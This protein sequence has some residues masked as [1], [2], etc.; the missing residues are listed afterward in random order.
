MDIDRTIVFAAD[1]LADA[2]SYGDALSQPTEVIITDTNRKRAR[3]W[4][5]IREVHG[6]TEQVGSEPLDYDPTD[7]RLPIFDDLPDTA[8]TIG[9]HRGPIS[10]QAS[11]YGNP[12][13]YTP[14]DRAVLAVDG[15]ISTAWTVAAFSEARGE[16]I[17]IDLGGERALTDMTLV[18][19]QTSP[20]ANRHITEIA[21]RVDGSLATIIGL[22]ERS[23][24]PAGQPVALGVTGSSIEIEITDTNMARRA[25]YPGVSPVG[26]AEI[27]L[28]LGV[29]QEVIR[30]PRALVDA[31]GSELDRHAL[32][33]VLTRQRSNPREPV[34]DDPEPAMTRAVPLPDNRTFVV[35]G[36]GRLSAR[37]DATLIDELVG[38]T[39]GLDGVGLAVRSSVRLPGDLPSRPSAALDG[40][41]AS[42]WTGDFGVQT[43]QWIEV[44]RDELI[45]ESTITIDVVVD[46]IHSVP[47]VVRLFIDGVD[48]GPFNT[49]LGLENRDPDTTRRIEIPLP[50]AGR[51]VRLMIEA[52]AE[53]TTLDWYSNEPTVMP[54]SIAE[55]GLGPG[56]RFGPLSPI[57][58]GCRDDL[59]SIDGSPARVAVSGAA[60]DAL[61]RRELQVTG[62]EPV[63]VIGGE[64][65]IVTSD[66]RSTGIDIDQL[67]LRSKRPVGRVAPARPVET[68]RHSDVRLTVD[69]PA[70]DH[71]RWLVLGQSDNAGWRATVDGR[72]LGDAIVVDGF[73][74]AWL[75][76][77]GEVWVVDLEWMPQRLV[78]KAVAISGLMLLVTLGLV[79]RGRRDDQ[80]LP[81][82]P[83]GEPDEPQLGHLPFFR[84]R[85]PLLSARVTALVGVLATAFVA[86]NLPQ[87]LLLAPLLGS[88]VA[89][90][91][92]HARLAGTLPLG[93]AFS[94]GMAA[95]YVMAEQIKLRHPSDFVWPQQF[96]EVHILGVIAILMLAGEYI[97]ITAR[98]GL[99]ER[100]PESSP[101]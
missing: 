35:S 90:A 63:D 6:Y 42:A 88:A 68:V 2:D 25:T 3:R 100:S 94:L 15:D 87:W 73:A 45:D 57:D 53:R 72:D 43:G 36:T 62:C 69:V 70:A 19:P 51:V 31:L 10:I 65:L 84:R 50:A 40:D 95:L 8:R 33:V 9:E 89:I 12:V 86:L 76:P 48:R 52:V 5:T 101:D 56:V 99:R 26:F 80:P 97:R 71:D 38:W 18:Q 17:V 32:S 96:D 58:T 37:S 11:A 81:A 30:T 82:A 24:G 21:V 74:N 14:D 41:P 91:S 47:E 22:D 78:D 20:A 93:A 67:V 4:G 13:T 55:I 75:V 44:E 49:G 39:V 60:A 77:A 54:V 16:R 29:V 98:I 59:L 79:W 27:D 85:G 1:L 28:G 46:R 7:N 64:A 61:A 23:R 83:R 92:R 34:R 66:G